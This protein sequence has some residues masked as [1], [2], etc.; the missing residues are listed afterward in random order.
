MGCGL[1][2][3]QV[4]A[5]AEPTR[6]KAPCAISLVTGGRALLVVVPDAD[7]VTAQVHIANQDMG[8][9]RQGQAV[10]VKL[11]AFPFTRHGTLPATVAVLGADAAVDERTGQ[12]TYPAYLTLARSS[13]VVEGREVPI[14]PGMNVVAEIKTGQRRLIEYLISPVQTL[15]DESLRER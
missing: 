6:A 1:S 9:V 12:A 3:F 13:V 8:F 10:T 7:R 4:E 14:T 5:W 15:A 2:G 11:E